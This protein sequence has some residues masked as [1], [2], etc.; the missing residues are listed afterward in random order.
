MGRT[1]TLDPPAGTNQ[2]QFVPVLVAQGS[3]FAD[4]AIATKR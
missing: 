2:V 4:I 3:L 1:T